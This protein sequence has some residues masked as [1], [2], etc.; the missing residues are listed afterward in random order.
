MQNLLIF[1]QRYFTLFLFLL[2]EFVC[3]FLLFQKEGYRQT[4]FLSSSN[5]V[6][7]F[8]L[9]KVNN[10]KDFF[11]LRAS[12]DSLLVQNARLL[13]STFGED[14]ASNIPPRQP[15]SALDGTF[16]F[17]PA[18]IVNNS[19]TQTFNY[20]TINKGRQDGL[21]PRMGVIG[22]S[23]VVGIVRNVSEKYAVVTSLL[24]KKAKVSALLP[25]DGSFGSVI[26]DDPL[27]DARHGSLVDISKDTELDKGDSVL[28][29][30]YSAIFPKGLLIGFVDKVGVQEA[31][32]FLDIE[33]TFATNFNNLQYVYVIENKDAEER[34]NLEESPADE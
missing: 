11:H 26:W 1:L 12:N 15:D 10:T 23:G 24:N 4:V 17:I 33:I 14:R 2:L 31:S 9:N 3:L 18:R 22:P 34:L 7:G 16:R 28:T 6:S 13:D 21:A 25:K 8:F 5:S 27:I 30:G 19:T 29:S 20:I 32:N